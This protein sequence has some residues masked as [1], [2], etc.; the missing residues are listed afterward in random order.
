MIYYKRL[1]KFLNVQRGWIEV[2]TSLVTEVQS[3]AV[4]LYLG[5]NWTMLK[6]N[7]PDWLFTDFNYFFV[8]SRYL[9]FYFIEGRIFDDFFYSVSESI[10]YKILTK[11]CL[12][13]FKGN[14]IKILCKEK[15]S[16][17]VSS[18]HLT[19]VKNEHYISINLH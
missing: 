5:A 19:N 17:S 16:L 3:K 2:A 9:R 8:V 14:W 12:K 13:N 18:F 6:V 10:W 15:K 11:K 1:L 4:L 7:I